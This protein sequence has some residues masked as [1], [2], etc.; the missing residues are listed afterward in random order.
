MVGLALVK[1]QDIM[2]NMIIANRN[3]NI[4]CTQ[5]G[6]S[7]AGLH[8]AMQIGYLEPDDVAVLD[9]T[10]HV[11]KFSLFQDMYFTDSFAPDFGVK[12][13][14]ELQNAPRLVHPAT[15]QKY[16]RPGAPLSEVDME[17][18]VHEMTAEIAKILS[19][20]SE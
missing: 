19:L 10:A 7:L 12:P 20:S 5:G 17:H 8:E 1:E 14:A 16:P 15:L 6:E 11:L 13:K 9:S 2:D 4:V 3:G 18:F